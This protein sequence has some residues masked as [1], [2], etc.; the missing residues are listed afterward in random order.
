[1]FDGLSFNFAE[2]HWLVITAIAVYAWFVGRLSASAKDVTDLR[3]RVVA[4]EEAQRNAPTRSELARIESDIR[5]VRTNQNAQ[6]SQIEVVRK[7]VVRIENYLLDK[8]K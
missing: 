5:E 1:M 8:G 6:S 3:M 4:I 7:G 2:A